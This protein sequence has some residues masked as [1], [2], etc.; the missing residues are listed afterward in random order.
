MSADDYSYQYQA[1]LLAAGKLYAEDPLYDKAHSLHD[2]IASNNLTDY[3]GRRF[4]KYPP[5][6]PAL[7]AVGAALKVPWLVD[8]VLG[9]LLCF[10]ITG[11]VERRMGK[12][13][14]NVTWLLLTSCLFFVYYAASGRAQRAAGGGE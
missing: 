7:L 12:K 11:Y 5:G 13:L 6:W 10:L 4:S 2:C 8:P 9:A 14:I 3:H 1:R